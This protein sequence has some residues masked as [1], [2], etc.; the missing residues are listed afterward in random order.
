MTAEVSFQGEGAEGALPLSSA[1]L[2]LS[3]PEA[4]DL[5]LTVIGPEHYWIGLGWNL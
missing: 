4:Q 3:T 5:D 2:Q 1:Y